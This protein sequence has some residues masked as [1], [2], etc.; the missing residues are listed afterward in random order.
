MESPTQ[1]VNLMALL[2][3]SADIVGQ[4][5]KAIKRRSGYTEEQ[6]DNEAVLLRAYGKGTEVL[7]DRESGCKPTASRLSPGT[8][9]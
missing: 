3:A 2:A 9:N 4:L 8:T 7:I 6:I 5:L 1:Y